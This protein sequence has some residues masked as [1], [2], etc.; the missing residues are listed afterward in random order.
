MLIWR[1]ISIA[2][3]GDDDFSSYTVIGVALLYC[4]QI[5]VNVGG[6]TGMLPVT[7]VTSPFLSYGGSSLLINFALLGVVMSIS[8]SQTLR[9]N[10]DMYYVE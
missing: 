8:R 2:S 3:K 5:L 10:K 4:I 6:A 9:I 1:L 7:G